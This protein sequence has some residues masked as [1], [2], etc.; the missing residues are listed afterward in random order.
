MAEYKLNAN[1]G[2]VLYKGIPVVSV[3]FFYFKNTIIP[4]FSGSDH[5]YWYTSANN[6]VYYELMKHAC[7][8]DLE[9]FDF[10]RSREGTGPAKF[11]EYMGFEPIPLHYYY[12]SRNHK[13]IPN[14][15]PSNKKFNLVSQIWS[16][17]PLFLTKSVGPLI[18][19]R[20]P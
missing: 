4:Y 15:T 10:G 14:I 20:I 13:N 6:V 11:K 7:E 1:I 12:Y 9:Y 17:L 5:K 16:H 2:T 8:L 18:V 3:L 19:K